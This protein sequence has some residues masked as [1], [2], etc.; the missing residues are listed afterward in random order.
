MAKEDKKEKEDIETF[1]SKDV[2]VTSHK[3]KK[4]F[5][6]DKRY[7][8]GSTIYLPDGKLKEKLISNKFI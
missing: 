5:I 8:T 1:E 7:P 2:S 6:L 4:E 3:V